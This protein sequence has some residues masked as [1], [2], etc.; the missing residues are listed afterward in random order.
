[1][2]E[3]AAAAN[4]LDI[5]DTAVADGRFKTLAAALRNARVDVWDLK[6]KKLVRS[7]WDRMQVDPVLT[8]D[9]SNNGQL[10]AT[11]SGDGV[12]RMWNANS[13][14]LLWSKGDSALM[15]KLSLTLNP[16]PPKPPRQARSRSP[17]SR[18]LSPTSGSTSTP[19]PSSCTAA[20]H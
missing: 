19:R 16:P 18:P 8:L 20:H 4:T 6:T 11:G 10:L 12:L 9:F 2:P 5:V 3:E 17:A 1:M 7:I 15:S 13:G 14:S